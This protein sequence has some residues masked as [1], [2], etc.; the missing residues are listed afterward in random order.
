MSDQPRILNLYAGIGGNR[1][2]WKANVT[3]VE[4]DPKIAAIYQR[5]NPNDS[6]IVGDAHRHLLEHGHEFDVVW[7]SPPCQ[8]HTRMVKFTRHKVAK[9]PD[10]TLLSEIL[11][12]QHSKIHAWIVENVVPYYE[13]EV[14]PSIRIGRHLFWS[15][16]PI[17]AEDV[18]RP[19][20]FINQC[21]VAGKLAMQEW[22]GI[23]YP[24]NVYYGKN[25]CPAQ[26][27][28]NCVHPLI[29]MQILQSA[30]K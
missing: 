20:N 23:H 7:S 17:F 9:H 25:H 10:P 29:G 11:F 16:R 15:N 26:V 21:T 1:K 19:K 13:P 27:L 5:L 8:T 12:L 24:E 30:L 4:M 28:R 2:L 6:V 18:P 14:P 22:L 3:A